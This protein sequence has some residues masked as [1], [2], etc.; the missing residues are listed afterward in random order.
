MSLA[1]DKERVAK[2]LRDRYG[3]SL[4][5][6]RIYNLLNKNAKIDVKNALSSLVT[7]GR[8]SQKDAQGLFFACTTTTTTS[9]TTTT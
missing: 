4:N 5:W 6:H 3:V 1:E 2:L 9:T 8:I 7:D